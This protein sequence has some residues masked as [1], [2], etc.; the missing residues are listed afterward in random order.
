[1][2]TETSKQNQL[3]VLCMLSRDLTSILC[4][5]VV[6]KTDVLKWCLVNIKC[7]GLIKMIQCRQRPN[8]IAKI[9]VVG[10]QNNSINNVRTRVNGEVISV[11]K[12]NNQVGEQ[13]LFRLAMLIILAPLLIIA[14]MSSSDSIIC[15]AL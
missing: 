15:W 13:P 4:M 7:N 5:L 9:I 12:D 1:M 2:L 14:A 11:W 6:L 8:V 3:S 10:I